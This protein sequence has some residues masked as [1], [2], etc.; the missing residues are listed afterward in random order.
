MF[1]R[2]LFLAMGLGL[3]PVD[4]GCL[5]AFEGAPPDD[6]ARREATELWIRECASCHGLTGA[7]DGQHAAGLERRPHSFADAC[8][9]IEDAWI[10]RV[11]LEGGASFGGDPAMKS[12]HALA[13]K[14]EVLAALVA[15]VQGF[16]VGKPCDGPVHAP[17]VGPDELD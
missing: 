15:V 2:Q 1:A 13:A 17:I 12:R 5:S 14:P 8:H 7:A 4:D 3:A 11:I 16:R 6:P 10:A 9:P